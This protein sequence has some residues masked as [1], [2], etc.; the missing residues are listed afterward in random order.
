MKILLAI[1]GTDF[2]GTETLL[3]QLA[4]GLTLRGHRVAVMSLKSPGPVGRRLAEDGISISTLGM[5][6]RVGPLEMLFGSIRL[7]W[8]LRARDFEVVHSFLPRANIMTRIANRISGRRRVH[9][10]NE[11]STDLQRSPVIVYLNRLTARWTDR[12]FAVSPSVKEIL[13]DREGLPGEKIEVL[14]NSIDVRATESVKP[15]DMMDL[16]GVSRESFVFASVGRLTPVKGHRYLLSAFAT[17]SNQRSGLHLVIVGDGPLED[18]LRSQAADLGIEKRVHFVGFRPD[19]PGIL[20][21]SSAMV[22]PSLQE[23]LPV[24]I[25]EAMVCSCP[26]IATGVGGVPSVVIDEETGL[27]VQPAEN[28]SSVRTQ[29]PEVLETGESQIETSQGVWSLEQA[30]LRLVDEPELRARLSQNA[31]TRVSTKFDFK[32]VIQRLEAAYR[33][34]NE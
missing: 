20:K 14:D 25:L 33:G 32:A 30:M 34:R 12:I 9:L 29:D 2:G 17:I 8:W 23:G 5:R 27:L 28:W 4:T 11:E 3:A 15:V 1:N 7:A 10:S 13:V 21:S 19:V 26:V 16:C 18:A 6:E 22:L 31:F 24:T